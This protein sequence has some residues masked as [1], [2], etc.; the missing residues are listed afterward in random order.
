M[1]LLAGASWEADVGCLSA[2]CGGPSV[3][4]NLGDA[5]FCLGH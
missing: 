5:H 2:L 4:Q 3:Q 1:A